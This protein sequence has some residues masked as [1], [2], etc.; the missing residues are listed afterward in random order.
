MVDTVVSV[1]F[2]LSILAVIL[3]LIRLLMSYPIILKTIIKR[4][5]KPN[6]R[7]SLAEWAFIAEEKPRFRVDYDELTELGPGAGRL[8]QPS[9][10]YFDKF[11]ADV[12]L[13]VATNNR[14]KLD[15]EVLPRLTKKPQISVKEGTHKHRI[16]SCGPITLPTPNSQIKEGDPLLEFEAAH[17]DQESNDEIQLDMDGLKITESG[18]DFFQLRLI[19]PDRYINRH[20]SSPAINP[21]DIRL[22]VTLAID[23]SEFQIPFLNLNLP[24]SAGS[25]EY[26]SDDI[27]FRIVESD[28]GR[29]TQEF[30]SI[31]LS[32]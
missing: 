19:L 17:K 20:S 9:V 7:L 10:Q 28:E 16:V 15:Y 25:V 14:M 1:G 32:F 24:S 22:W 13:H 26:N 11:E 29:E 31:K 6:V 4:I 30:T 12:N 8:L 23:V 5:H 2:L 21:I 27:Y 3:G 18:H